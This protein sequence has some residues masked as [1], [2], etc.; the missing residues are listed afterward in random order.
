MQQILTRVTG[1]YN[2]QKLLEAN[3]HVIVMLQAYWRGVLFRREFNKRMGYLA[4]QSPHVVKIQVSIC[5]WS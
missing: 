1:D 5:F 2:R 3:E 4:E